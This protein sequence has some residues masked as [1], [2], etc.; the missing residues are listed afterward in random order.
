MTGVRSLPI[1]AIFGRFTTGLAADTIRAMNPDLPRSWARVLADELAAPYFRDL[2]AFVEQER[3]RYAVYPPPNDVFAALA[4]TPYDR[5]RVLLLGQDP[6]HGEGQAHGLCFS[7]R[8]GVPPPPSLVNIFRELHDDLG[9]PIPGHGYLAA[10][11]RQGIL[12]LNTVLTVRAGEAGSHR[13]QGWEQFTDAM[14]RRV[15]EKRDPVVFV[16]WG[17]PAQQKARWI[18]TRRHAIVTAA[19]PSPLS[20]H[21]G[22]LGTRPF[23]AIN[24]ALRSRGQPEVDWC[25]PEEA[26]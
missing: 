5:V 26:A 23:S 10:W 9:C 22:F 8:P 7:V 4:L 24:R 12:L 18:D 6:Y 21:R 1:L 14:I 17:R 16:L 25:L 3:R 2:Q 11:A 19:H 13:G 20:A 15:N